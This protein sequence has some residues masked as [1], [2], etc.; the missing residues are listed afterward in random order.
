MKAWG[1]GEESTIIIATRKQDGEVPE[2]RLSHNNIINTNDIRLKFLTKTVYELLPTP[3]NKNKWFKTNEKCAMC[4]EEGARNHILARCQV[5]CA[6]GKY[7][8]RET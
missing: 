3:T 2:K 5:S 8:K 6:Q 7:K 4:G 1:G